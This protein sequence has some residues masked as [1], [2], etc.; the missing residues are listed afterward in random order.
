MDNT[1]DEALK[2]A[3]DDARQRGGGTWSVPKRREGASLS[4][5]PDQGI[6]PTK[7]VER[8]EIAD[9][10]VAANSPGASPS[11]VGD[12]VALV[13][14]GVFAGV[15]LLFTVAW[16]ITALRNP[17]QIADPLGNIM[18]LLGLW[19]AV[20]AG[21]ATFVAS[22]VA[23]NNRLWLRFVCLVLGALVLIPWPYF[24]WAG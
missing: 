24:T 21:P 22:L 8:A 19:F 23:G 7:V 10:T 2:W 9:D 17:V 11:S 1:D 16:L 15:Y 6:E 5:S 20:A 12:S 13:A 14:T 18:F 4:P 3:G